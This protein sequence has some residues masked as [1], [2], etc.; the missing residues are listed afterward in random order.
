M[1]RGDVVPG[2]IEVRIVAWTEEIDEADMIF[3]FLPHDAR[4]VFWIHGQDNVVDVL[5]DRLLIQADLGSVTIT[6]L[7]CVR[8]HLQPHMW[9]ALFAAMPKLRWLHLEDSDA[10]RAFVE[11]TTSP[12]KPPTRMAYQRPS[13]HPSST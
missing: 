4:L 2:V 9:A 12:S 5:I 8:Y 11:T 10:A 7:T 6:Q 13:I 3:E 1:D